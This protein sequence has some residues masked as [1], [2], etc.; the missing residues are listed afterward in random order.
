MT[1]EKRLTNLQQVQARQKQYKDRGLCACG[2]IPTPGYKDC[3]SCR[4]TRKARRQ[5]YREEGCCQC[6][7]P[8]MPGVKKNGRPYKSCQQCIE[9]EKA[10]KNRL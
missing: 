8:V 5:R 7:K 4:Q 10:R 9:R 3:A 1:E 2:G 6:G